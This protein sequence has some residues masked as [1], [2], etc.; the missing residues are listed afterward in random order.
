LTGG[1]LL[2]SVPQPPR[3]LKTSDRF[4]Y[5]ST[6]ALILLLTFLGFFR[7]F[8][9]GQG[10]SG[11]ITP[12]IHG[13]V[14]LHGLAITAWYVLS[15]VQALLIAAK[16]RALHMKLGWVGAAIAVVILISGILVAIRS[17]RAGPG[18]HLF[19]MAYPDFLLVMW[20]EII[21]FT[22]FVTAGI[23]MRKRPAVHRVMM[24]LASLSLLLGA[25]A[26][27][28]ALIGLFGGPESRLAFF[29]PVF[30]LAAMLVVVRW[31]MTRSLDRWFAGGAALMMVAYLA[32]EQMSRT[33]AWRQMA[34]GLIKG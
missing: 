28:P 34:G 24:L 33:E 23:L 25:T 31:V 13:L 16:N 4:F 9:K 15:L 10:F 12:G 5:S 20:T 22:L 1:A 17:V 26:R 19:G 3:T 11:Q 29:G 21:V 32:A 6:A 8:T 27:I 14:V 30:A 18:F 7:F 2:R